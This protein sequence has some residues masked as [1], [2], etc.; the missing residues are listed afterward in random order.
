MREALQQERKRERER[1]RYDD[2][3]IIYELYVLACNDT[4][5]QMKKFSRV[6]LTSKQNHFF[7]KR[8]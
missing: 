7:L 6:D 2:N 1:T 8:E 3:Q 5:L 4:E